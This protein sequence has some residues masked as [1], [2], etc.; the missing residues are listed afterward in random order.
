M[1]TFATAMRGKGNKP[2]KKKGKG[3]GEKHGGDTPDAE[4][5]QLEALEKKEGKSKLDD[6]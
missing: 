5:K 6:N 4:L 3:G 2:R 1:C